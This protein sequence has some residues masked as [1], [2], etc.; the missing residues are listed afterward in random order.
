MTQAHKTPGAFVVLIDEPLNRIPMMRDASGK[1][2]V[3]HIFRVRKEE[4]RGHLHVVSV[5]DPEVTMD[6]WHD[7]RFKTYHGPRLAELRRA[8][9]R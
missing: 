4:P 3:D 1:P 9:P 6:G 8:F 5:D 7:D 2:W